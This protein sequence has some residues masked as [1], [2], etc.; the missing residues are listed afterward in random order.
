MFVIDL[1]QELRMEAISAWKVLQ[2]ETNL[3]G[4]VPSLSATGVV[5]GILD[6]GS[7]KGTHT[8]YPRPSA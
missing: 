5:H 3:H 7:L 4:V 1:I 8:S 2:S 6:P